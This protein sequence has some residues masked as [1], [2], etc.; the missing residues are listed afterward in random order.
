M[1]AGPCI[2]YCIICDG[3]NP[4]NLLWWA[5]TASPY[6]PSDYDH[7]HT[8]C[9]M[10][11]CQGGACG[12]DDF[13]SASGTGGLG[14]MATQLADA[15]P[16]VLNLALQVFPEMIS[17][18]E[19]RQAFRLRGCQGELIA[20]G[21][22]TC[23]AIGALRWMLLSSAKRR[24]A[25]APGG[26]WSLLR[27]PG[28]RMAI[29]ERSPEHEERAMFVANVLLRRTGVVFR[30]TIARERFP[31]AWRVVLRALRTLELRGEVLGGRFVSGFS[32][33]QFALPGAAELLKRVHRDG[34]LPALEV[35]AADPLNFRGILTPD[36][37][38]RPTLSLR[39]KLG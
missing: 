21:L 17:Y 34:D 13:A 33:E 15:S 18:N 35:S 20:H 25:P 19:D 12:G 8:A 26:R 2:T 32:G 14:A 1:P 30:Q 27:R 38:V 39:V 3:M 37:R 31:V 9:N 6:L 29:D 16:L 28:P 4:P 23:D 24:R 5:P 36:A 10:T 7:V 11:D 22:L